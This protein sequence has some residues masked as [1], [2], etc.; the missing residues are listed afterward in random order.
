M[1]LS[2]HPGYQV[3][4]PQPMRCT[5]RFV[6]RVE[7]SETRGRSRQAIPDFA[8]APSGLRGDAASAHPVRGAELVAVGVAQIGEIEL[9]GRA[10]AHAGR[11][12]DRRAAR[13]DAGLVPGVDLRGRVHREADGA[14]IG[15][16]RG[17]PID[18]L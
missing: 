8:F 12:F 9:A 1:S 3:T 5:A 11:V 16:A 7:R 13:R 6:A 15:V 17:L 14:A 4:P 18:R 10:L 2:L